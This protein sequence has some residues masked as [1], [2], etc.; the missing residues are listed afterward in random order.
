M[1]NAAFTERFEIVKR[2]CFIVAATPFNI[3]VS[4]ILIGSP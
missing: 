2:R 3:P 4:P 1:C